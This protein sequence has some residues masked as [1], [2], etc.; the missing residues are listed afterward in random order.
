MGRGFVFGRKSVSWDYRS[1]A[2]INGPWIGPVK[3]ERL[4]LKTWGVCTSAYIPLE[5]GEMMGA[6][7]FLDLVGFFGLLGRPGAGRDGSIVL[8][9]FVGEGTAHRS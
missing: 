3:H 9:C 2:R 7:I 6:G 1:W 5:V 8:V 4:V